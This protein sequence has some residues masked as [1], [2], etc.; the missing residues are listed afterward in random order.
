MDIDGIKR[1]IGQLNNCNLVRSEQ[2]GIRNLFSSYANKY[3]NVTLVFVNMHTNNACKPPDYFIRKL[4][5]NK[6]K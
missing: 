2:G 3:S 6:L 1:K 4:Q 5:E